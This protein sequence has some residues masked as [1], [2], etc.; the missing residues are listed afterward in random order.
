MAILLP[1]SFAAA[2]L[3]KQAAIPERWGYATDLRARLLS[4]AVPRPRRSVHQGAYYQ[5]LTQRA[6]IRAGPLEPMLV[7]PQQA[8]EAA[9]RLLV[10]RGWDGKRPADG[11]CARRRLRNGEALASAHVAALAT[12]LVRRRGAT[13]V[14]VGS[15]ADRGTTTT[16][17]ER[18]APDAR[19]HVI[20]VTGQTTLATLAGVSPSRRCAS[21]TTPA[22]CTWPRP[23]GVPVVALFGPTRENETA[24]LTRAG[25]RTEVLTHPVWCRPCMLRECPIDHRCMT[26]ISPERVYTAIDTLSP[27]S[28]DSDE[29]FR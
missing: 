25:G 28:L 11:A 1:N 23:S 2:W 29:V 12:E 4:R 14:L 24:P 16:V 21:R 20:D 13:C 27:E 8:T 3:V 9:R 18:V 7:V 5:H 6:R 19:S 26:R 10:E 17:R 22:R 15:D